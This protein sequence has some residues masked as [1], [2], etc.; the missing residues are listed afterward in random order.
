[1]NLEEHEISE[2]PRVPSQG[3]VT[4]W[5]PEVKIQPVDFFLFFKSRGFMRY[6]SEPLSSHKFCITGAHLSW[7]SLKVGGRAAL[8][9]PPPPFSFPSPPQLSTGPSS[10]SQPLSFPC[11]G[12]SGSHSPQVGQVWGWYLPPMT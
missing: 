10:S 9:P 1:M 7:P 8:G 4:N 11:F 5:I 2:E 6:I 12:G 3:E